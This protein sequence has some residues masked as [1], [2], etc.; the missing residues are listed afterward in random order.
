MTTYR[1]ITTNDIKIGATFEGGTPW[2]SP[3]YGWV[4]ILNVTL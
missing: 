1:K 3:K 4:W 2:P